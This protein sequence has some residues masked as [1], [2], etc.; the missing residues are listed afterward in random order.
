MYFISGPCTVLLGLGKA[1]GVISKWVGQEALALMYIISALSIQGSI[2]LVL[3]LAP[4]SLT[5][6]PGFFDSFRARH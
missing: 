6:F 2:A 1:A 3:A 4:S 5:A